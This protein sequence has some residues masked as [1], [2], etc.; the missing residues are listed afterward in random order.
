MLPITSAVTVYCAL[1]LLGLSFY[2]SL[3]RMK[4]GVTVGFGHDEDLLR[5][6]RAQGNFTEYVPLVLI[7]IGIS[8]YRGA[9]ATGLWIVALLLAGGRALHAAG[10]LGGFLPLRGAGMLATYAALLGGAGLVAFG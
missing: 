9:W 6:I 7:L 5:R 8:E 1:L 3:G 10:M 2:V 4:T